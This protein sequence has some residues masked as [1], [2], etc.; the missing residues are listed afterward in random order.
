MFVISTK[1]V[2]IKQNIHVYYNKIFVSFFRK[3]F[4]SKL[5]FPTS[6]TDDK[7][8][9][10]EG[11]EL[12]AAGPPAVPLW[13]WITTGWFS[14]QPDPSGFCSPPTLLLEELQELHGGAVKLNVV[15]KFLVLQL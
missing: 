11:A 12:L 2:T 4:C 6:F 3:S 13:C 15:G 9:V 8:G 14:S 5:P 10:L 1:V 7:N